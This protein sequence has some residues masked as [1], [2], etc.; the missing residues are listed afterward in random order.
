MTFLVEMV[1]RGWETCAKYCILGP[2][3]IVWPLSVVT[4][5]LVTLGMNEQPV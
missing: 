2:G 4:S 3:Q 5:Q 1:P